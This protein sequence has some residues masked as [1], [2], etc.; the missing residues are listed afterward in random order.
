MDPLALKAGQYC[1]GHCAGEAAIE[2]A[3]GNVRATPSHDCTVVVT[4]APALLLIDNE[5]A[6]PKSIQTVG[7]GQTLTIGPPSE[8]I[9]SYLHVAGGFA[10]GLFFTAKAPRPER[11]SVDYMAVIFVIMTLFRWATARHGSIYTVRTRGSATSNN[12]PF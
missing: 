3:Y 4:G 9:Y 5:P 2:I 1:L 8:G 10:L 12:E 11:A 7:A 6:P